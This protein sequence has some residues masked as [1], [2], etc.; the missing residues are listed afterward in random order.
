MAAKF[1]QILIKMF[2]THQAAHRRPTQPKHPVE[3]AAM[4]ILNLPTT[5]NN[6]LTAPDAFQMV[7]PMELRFNTDLSFMENHRFD[8]TATFYNSDYENS[9]AHSA[10]FKS[11]ML[12]VLD[13]LVDTYP[14]GSKLVEVGCGKGDFLELAEATNHFDCIG[15]DET[16]SGSNSRIEQRYLVEGDKIDCDIVVLR[17]VL[18]HIPQPQNFLK[19]LKSVFGETDIYIEVPNFDWILTHNTFFDITYEHVNYFTQKALAELFDQEVR[20]AQLCFDD[21]YQYVIANLGSLGER[22]EQS[23]TSDAWKMVSIDE[24][25]PKLEAQIEE[26][27]R[28]VGPNQSCYFWGGATKGCMF[29]WHA[30]RLERL[31]DRVPYA[32]DIN[33]GKQGRWLPGSLVS[34]ESPDRFFKDAKPG[35]V[36]A[37]A[38]P[39]YKD[40]IEA[41]LKHHKLDFVSVYGL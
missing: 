26:L 35:D 28:L 31:V 18:E 1:N 30:N 32:I 11:H 41:R 14:K 24:M 6:P 20:A 25:F 7:G 5:P 13:L 10:Q 34:I 9:Q 38:N 15:Y 3:E 29:L 39:A 12:K 33:P 4:T 17:H 22:F 36:L 19:M 16:Y 2:D 40:E 23:Y 27:D 8:E 37:I 21:Q